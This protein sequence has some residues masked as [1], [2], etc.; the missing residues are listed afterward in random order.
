MQNGKTVSAYLVPAQVEKLD[1]V[2]GSLPRSQAMNK[3][4]AYILGQDEA[5]IRDLIGVP[6]E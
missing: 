1:T 2:R 5:W 3:I 6:H 4:L